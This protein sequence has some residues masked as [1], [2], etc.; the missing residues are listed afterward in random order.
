MISFL[1]KLGFSSNDTVFPL[2]TVKQQIGFLEA[3]R[4]SNRI[5]ER[6]YKVSLAKLNAIQIPCQRSYSL[7]AALVEP[8]R[9][10]FGVESSDSQNILESA[11]RQ[12][13]DPSF[14]NMLKLR[15]QLSKAKVC[16]L[17]P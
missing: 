7:I 12:A 16:E 15:R 14:K 2:S 3:A 6:T 4:Q 1:P 11:Q 10:T 8:L 13:L 5:D 9:R 17:P